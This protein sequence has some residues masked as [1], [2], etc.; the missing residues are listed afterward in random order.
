[1]NYNEELE[2]IANGI[3]DQNAEAISDEH[4]PNYTNREFMNCVIIFQNAM[5]D[6][7]YDTQEYDN[8]PIDERVK[9]ATKCGED[10]RKFIHTYTGLDTHNVDNFV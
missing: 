9:M 10:L 6:K 4:K 3:L 2:A 5:M 8:M 1:M 7:I